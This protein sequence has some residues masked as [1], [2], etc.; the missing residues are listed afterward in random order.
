MDGFAAHAEPA[1]RTAVDA[2]MSVSVHVRRGDYATSPEALKT[3]G[4]MEDDYY[5]RAC[6]VMRDLHPG[7]RFYVFSDDPTA[8]AE[9]FSGQ[10]D[11]TVLPAGRWE[12][13]LYLMHRCRHHITANS[14]FSWWGAW[15]GRPGG[16]VV[17][18]RLWF[19]RDVLATKCVV[20]LYPDH[21]ITL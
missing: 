1:Y 13:D 19:S 10:K 11:V 4:L 9:L 17:A 6:G 14:S 2:E 7:C 3:H 20:D 5:R 15:L 18:P 21:W 16:T 8:A 12:R